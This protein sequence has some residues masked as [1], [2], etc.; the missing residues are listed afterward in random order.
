LHGVDKWPPMVITTAEERFNYCDPEFFSLAV[1]LMSND[2]GSYTFLK[3]RNLKA[4]ADRKF[5]ESSE[6]MIK[7]WQ[8]KS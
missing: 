7:E 1:I 5:V 6:M 2:S 8:D 3:D 4:E